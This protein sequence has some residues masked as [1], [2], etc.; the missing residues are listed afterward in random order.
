MSSKFF[1]VDLENQNLFLI[2]VVIFSIK[3]FIPMKIYNEIPLGESDPNKSEEQKKI[4]HELICLMNS[5][6]PDKERIKELKRQLK[7]LKKS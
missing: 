1:Y 6:R 3:N 5:W 4:E 2:F 7:N